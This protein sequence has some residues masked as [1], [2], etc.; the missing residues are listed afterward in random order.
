MGKRL[1]GYYYRLMR[2]PEKLLEEI[3]SYHVGSGAS[4]N[5]ENQRDLTL[6][7]PWDRNFKMNQL[8]FSHFQSILL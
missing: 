8:S 4:K 7:I 1:S 6:Q 3:Q 5:D 2:N